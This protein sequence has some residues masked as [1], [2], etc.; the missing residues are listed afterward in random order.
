MR[1]KMN[2]KKFSDVYN[3]YFVVHADSRPLDIDKKR[4]C[5]EIIKEYND[6]LKNI[7]LLKQRI[8]QE[9]YFALR[10]LR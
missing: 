1:L 4:R 9:K 10:N 3:C 5:D 6:K 7:E 2:Q 8:M